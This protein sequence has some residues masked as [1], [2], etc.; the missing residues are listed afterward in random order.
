MKTTAIDNE[1]F[2]ITRQRPLPTVVSIA[3]F[4]GERC[5]LRTN[6]F[7]TYQWLID[8]LQDKEIGFVGHNIAYDFG[9]IAATWPQTLP[10]IFRAYEQGRVTDTG[11]RQQLFDIAFGRVFADDK[12]AAYSLASLYEKIFDKQLPNKHSILDDPSNPRYNYG[13]LY[14]VPLSEWPKESI[15]YAEKD[16]IVTWEIWNEQNKV[17]DLLRDDAFQAYSA[18]C[19]SLISAYG[20]KTD[21]V[22]TERLRASME[23]KMKELEP[24]LIDA[25]LLEWDKRNQKF[26]KKQQPARERIVA[27]CE[28]RGV[29]PLLTKK[30]QIQID[31]AACYFSQDEVMLKRAKYSTCEKILST[32][33]SFI[34][35]GYVLPVTTRFH[36]A[37]TGRTTSSGPRLPLVGGNL[38][39]QPR[40]GGPDADILPFGNTPR[41][42]FIPRP[43][44]VYL[45]GDFSGAEL[46]ALAQVCKYKLGYSVLGDALLAGKDVH[47]LVAG[48]ALD[49]PYDDALERY[50]AGDKEVKQARQD[51]K[52]VNFGMAGGMGPATF[53]KIRLKDGQFWTYEK[54]V[55]LKNAWL[56]AFPEMTDYFKACQKELGP[57]E[58][59]TVEFFYTKRLRKIRGFSTMCNG[60]FQA[61]TADG[62]K[63]AINEVIRRCYIDPQSALYGC[64]PV[65]FVHDELILEVP[66]DPTKWQAIADEFAETMA[67]EFN[68]VVPDYPTKVDAVLMRRWSKAAEP[69]FDNEG[70]LIPWSD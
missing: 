8:T 47:L 25:G 57:T 51:A 31:K 64:R 22:Q 35:K 27:A 41:E 2:L 65:N 23:S 49:M 17:A 33:V 29:K 30:K 24:E 18:F 28:A 15:E 54:T 44:K 36:L 14:K 12:L 43:G 60:W 58:S 48:K 70:R 10:H 55:K 63:M 5:D 20:M 7:E 56:E 21:P 45:A 40:G 37:A 6:D 34:E 19:L 39:N 16:A 38:Q 46:H 53:I 26:I 68:K 69:T 13:K 61:L 59:S 9:T 50:K 66:D 32:Y 67:H 42:C 11:I 4:D 52:P 62:A 1:T 3:A